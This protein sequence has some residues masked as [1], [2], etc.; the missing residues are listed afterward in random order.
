[1]AY[2]KKSE[3]N[4]LTGRRIKPK[5]ASA[6]T[7]GGRNKSTVMSSKMRPGSSSKF[8]RVSSTTSNLKAGEGIGKLGGAELGGGSL[9]ASR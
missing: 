5:V 7:V 9:G 4:P 6:K 8:G 2:G 1:M 3:T